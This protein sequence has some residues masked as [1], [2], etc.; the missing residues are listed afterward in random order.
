MVI[1]CWES[2]ALKRVVSLSQTLQLEVA[3][4]SVENLACA[5]A[6]GGPV[7]KTVPATLS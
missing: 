1:G 2:A 3:T 4:V 5:Q 6:F 7:S